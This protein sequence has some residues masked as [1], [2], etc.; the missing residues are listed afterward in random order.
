MEQITMSF[1]I[2]MIFVAKLMVAVCLIC[3]CYEIYT[4]CY[5]RALHAVLTA[6]LLGICASVLSALIAL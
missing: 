4:K 3:A 2:A 6:I 5:L 1:T